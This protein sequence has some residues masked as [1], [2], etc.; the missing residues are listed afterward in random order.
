MRL[1]GGRA[2]PAPAE[3]DGRPD[4]NFNR[5][6]T[7]KQA[8]TGLKKKQNV[9]VR[10]GGA[11][12]R[13]PTLLRSGTPRTKDLGGELGAFRTRGRPWSLDWSQDRFLTALVLSRTWRWTRDFLDQHCDDRDG[14]TF[15]VLQKLNGPHTAPR[16]V[17][18]PT[19]D[20]HSRGLVVV[21]NPKLLGLVSLG[22]GT[23]GVR[24]H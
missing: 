7:E 16:A 24:E 9:N 20:V 5:L 1:D 18:C 2:H 8:E 21:S 23:K 15:G 14:S 17:V 19:P 11:L 13:R 6:T 22:D 4:E 12:Q 3:A 10:V